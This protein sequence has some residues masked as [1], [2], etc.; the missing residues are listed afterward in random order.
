MTAR[1]QG[2]TMPETKPLE[3]KSVTLEIKDAAKGQVEAVF[4][5]FDVIDHHSDWT[6][7]TAFEDGAEVLIGSWG[8]GTVF[9][10]PPVGKGVIKV[11]KKDARLVGNYFLDTAAGLEQFTTVKNVGGQQEWS[12][13]FEIKATGEVTEELRQRGVRR[14]LSK[15]LVH[16]VSPVMR[17]AGIDTRTVTAKCAKCGGDHAAEESG[18]G[19]PA[20]AASAAA[21]PVAEQKTD[22]K[23]ADKPV[24]KPA[25][26]TAEQKAAEEARKRQ[27]AEIDVEVE[28]FERTRRRLGY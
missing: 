16:E 8:H 1:A 5:T 2:V 10:E 27:R 12:Y 15:L 11:T 6:E 9:G 18:K 19:K 28:R 25:E 26:P 20:D 17:G 14:V 7:P 24:D 13:S 22:E 4:A 3:R 21:E 23:P